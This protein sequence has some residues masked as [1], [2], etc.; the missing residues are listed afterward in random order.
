MLLTKKHNKN[1]HIVSI[2]SDPIKT[3]IQLGSGLQCSNSVSSET[4]GQLISKCL[5]V[6]FNFFQKRDENMSHSIKNEFICLFVFCKNSRLGNLL[7]KLTELYWVMKIRMR[8]HKS[9]DLN[10][11]LTRQDSTIFGLIL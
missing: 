11:D 7:S 4:K 5:F 6:D 9:I 2:K 1:Q 8:L 10:V 3:Q